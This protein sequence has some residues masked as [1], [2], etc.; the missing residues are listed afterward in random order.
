MVRENVRVLWSLRDL[1]EI[2]MTP[3][4]VSFVYSRAGH[5]S[6]YAYLHG[7]QEP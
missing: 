1:P 2:R 4:R 6:D 7:G 5:S 3:M